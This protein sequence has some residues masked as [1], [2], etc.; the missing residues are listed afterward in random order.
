[1]KIERDHRNSM[2]DVKVAELEE[3]VK[4]DKDIIIKLTEEI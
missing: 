1:M 4:I 3:K 2:F